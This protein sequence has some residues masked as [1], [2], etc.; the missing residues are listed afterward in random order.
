[1]NF[2]DCK[3][4]DLMV[5]LLKKIIAQEKTEKKRRTNRTILTMGLASAISFRMFIF[6]D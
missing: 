4:A 6:S 2:L 3:E 1:M 5:F